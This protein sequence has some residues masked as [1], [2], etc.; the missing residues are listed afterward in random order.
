MSALVPGDVRRLTLSGETVIDEEIL[1][2]ELGR[3]R[4]IAVTPDGSLL[5][6]T[7]G[8]DGKIMRVTAKAVSASNLIGWE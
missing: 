7:D 2:D 4:H 3:I 5:L 1:F 6:A 8:S